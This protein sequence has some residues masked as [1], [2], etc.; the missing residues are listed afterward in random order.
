MR[1]SRG[2]LDAM[3]RADLDALVQGLGLRYD[4][5]A[6]ERL[7][8]SDPGW[9]PELDRAERDVGA[10]FQTLREAD[11]ALAEWPRAVARLAALWE[12]VLEEPPVGEALPDDEADEEMVLRDVA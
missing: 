5:G 1:V 11:A 6:A 7:A 10:L 2:I 3:A 9:R 4:A 12:R 8:R